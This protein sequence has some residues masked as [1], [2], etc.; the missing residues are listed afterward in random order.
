MINFTIEPCVVCGGK[1]NISPAVGCNPRADA[2]EQSFDKWYVVCQ[3]PSCCHC[4]EDFKVA[5]DAVDVWNAESLL[6]RN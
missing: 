4:T 5:F 3:N 6:S 1:A 2:T